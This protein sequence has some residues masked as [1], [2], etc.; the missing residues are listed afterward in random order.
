[1]RKTSIILFFLTSTVQTSAQD[2]LGKWKTVDDQTGK[3]KS[4]VH[5]YEDNGKI[6][7]RIIDIIN[8]EAKENLCD[9]CKG[10]KKN[11]PIMGMVIFDELE[12]NGDVYTG[13][14]ILDPGGGS[15]YNCKIW[16][17][18]DNPNILNVRGYIA[19]FFR[20]QYWVRVDE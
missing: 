1:M 11:K 2:I 4:I 9:G 17:D 7:G 13:G 12:K 3:A 15:E 5:I 10:E 20:T 18:E 8:D 14:K 6:C 16:I 19:F